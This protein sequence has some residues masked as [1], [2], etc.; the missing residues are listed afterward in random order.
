MHHVKLKQNWK[1]G[2]SRHRAM[3]HFHAITRIILLFHESRPEKR[4]YHAITLCITFAPSRQLFCYFTNHA[5][6]KMVNHA[7]T[8]TTGGASLTFEQ[9]H[10]IISCNLKKII[11]AAANPSFF[12]QILFL[13]NTFIFWKLTLEI[14]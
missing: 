8:P 7:I 10:I 3:H 1:K 11:T 6:K 2:L 14:I 13:R 12:K 9:L 5:L 4:A